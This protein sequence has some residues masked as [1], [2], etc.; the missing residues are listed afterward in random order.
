M[1]VS[2]TEKISSSLIITRSQLQQRM[3]GIIARSE[4][5]ME[6]GDEFLNYHSIGNWSQSQ[7]RSH[8][9][10]SVCQ[11][12]GSLY[13]NHV[14]GFQNRGENRKL[15]TLYT[16]WGRHLRIKD[17]CNEFGRPLTGHSLVTTQWNMTK[18]GKLT[19]LYVIFLAVGFISSHDAIWTLC[20]LE[21][22]PFMNFGTGNGPFA[23]SGHM[24][25]NPPCW[26]TSC[27]LGHPQQSDFIKTNLHFLCFGCPSALLALQH[28]GFCTM[29][30]LAA[31]GP[32]FD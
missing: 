8:K 9:N 26:R 31:K 18:L 23:A 20:K 29:W 14:E 17:I 30:P 12:W 4:V 15:E 27:P 5:Q 24:V 2:L 22:S 10:E 19:N 6:T 13:C 3:S 1:P 32:L 21:P 7:E 16:F 25:Q 28:G 11:V